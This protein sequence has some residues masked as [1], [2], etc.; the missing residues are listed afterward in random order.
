MWFANSSG[1]SLGYCSNDPI[2][3]IFIVDVISL[4]GPQSNVIIVDK[5][6]VMLTIYI[7]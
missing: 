7:I 4:V 5:E 6:E 2:K 1:I 3:A